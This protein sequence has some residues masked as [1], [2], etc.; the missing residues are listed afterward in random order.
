MGIIYWLIFLILIYIAGVLTL[1]HY[2][3]RHLVINKILE[4][5]KKGYY[6]TK[7]YKEKLNNPEVE[8]TCN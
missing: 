5:R 6:N 3:I 2:G 8:R 1:I 7:N 4:M